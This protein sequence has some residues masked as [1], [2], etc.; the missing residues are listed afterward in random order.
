MSNSP[1]AE[2]LES[3]PDAI[4]RVDG[5]PLGSFWARKD[6]A[7]KDG[8]TSTHAFSWGAQTRT[9]GGALAAIGRAF[10]HVGWFLLL[11]YALVNLAY[12]TREI[13]YQ[14][15]GST[16]AWHGDTG[17]GTVRVFGLV[18]TLI[19]V[20]AFCSVAIDLVAVQCFRGSATEANQVCAALP[21]VFDGLRGL[22][23]DSRAA[24]LGLVPVV[25]ILVLY[26]IARSG[27]VR[28]EA[29][30][31]TFGKQIGGQGEKGRPLLATRGFWA[32][33]RSRDTTEWLHVAGS[34]LLV[35]FLL[36]FDASFP[37]ADCIGAPLTKD[38]SDCLGDPDWRPLV[39]VGIAAVGLVF[40]V[41]GVIISSSTP[42]REAEIP[43]D[44]SKKVKEA[45][46]PDK[47]NRR[48]RAY[49][50]VCL[51]YGAVGYIVWVALTFTPLTD[52][53]KVTTQFIGLITAPLVLMSAALFLALYAVSW[54]VRSTWRRRTSATVLTLGAVALML[55]QVLSD[56]TQQWMLTGAAVVLVLIHLLLS[57]T[58]QANPGEAKGESDAGELRFRAWRGQG[59]A[60]VML[61]SLFVSMALSSLL[62]LG[63]ASWLG[64]PEPG[65]TDRIW[66]TPGDPLPVT[67]WD[68]P[69][70]YERFAVLL[71]V[72]VVAILILLIV[73]AIVVVPKL[74]RF[75][76]PTLA[77][78][79]KAPKDEG[80]AESRGG[81][82]APPVRYPDKL[83]DPEERVRI[84]A[85][86]RRS[87][88]L[89]HRG[90]PLFAWIAVLAA[91]G[92]F[93]LSSSI[94]FDAAKGV[95][96]GWAPGLPA[97]LR[98]AATAI[99]VALALAAVAAVVAN[100]ATN[101][102]RPL[103]VF[104][105][106]V[107][108]FP[109]AGHPF[110]PPCFAERAV[111][112]LAE[113]TRQFL[114]TSAGD[115]LKPRSAVILTAH[116]MGSTISAATILAL[117]GERFVEEPPAGPQLTDRI[118]LL[119]YGS[120]LRGY[121]SR[122]F[123]SVFGYQVLGVPG[124]LAPSLWNPDPWKKQV[125]AEFPAPSQPGD[126]TTRAAAKAEAA[127]KATARQ[128]V[129]T[130]AFRKDSLAWMLGAS[131]TTLPRWRNLWRRT[132][133]LGFPVF[134]YDSDEN[135]VDRGATETAPGYQW[136]VAKHS[137]YLGTE[138]IELA[139]VEL[140]G[141][142]SKGPVV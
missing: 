28:F 127:A 125:V 31:E 18:L 133:F 5:D 22:D 44:P 59:A 134:S 122:F 95:L 56:S 90:E 117:R 76:L 7:A 37:K 89:L 46:S 70:A 105:D 137:A 29:R 10:V 123:P 110:A 141:E 69:D 136:T 132:D 119:S 42:L 60:V 73:A 135:P 103:G 24:L 27:R 14:R 126:E 115:P 68:V 11:P 67:D 49:A 43:T 35:L 130:H 138:Q 118:A 55:S 75:T 26:F 33:A 65:K 57:R 17:S 114:R 98:A 48:K 45:A 54:R 30:V 113:H 128:E 111:P 124:L 86:A 88:H 58:S 8:V 142:L 91:V 78:K 102:D 4:E 52:T 139:R 25:V 96:E 40:V 77:W 12:W 97:G 20:A 62:V 106:V 81:V 32:A 101:G 15:D 13:R 64:T 51:V 2:M 112:E 23:V 41:I 66:R 93:S 84:R 72:V 1:P 19:A 104:W 47:R 63:V 74:V 85:T 108:F 121:F 82:E 94:V 109:R 21:A 99:L 79:G 38:L 53:S 83:V 50:F 140:V 39:F 71:M 61:L 120:Q 34:L 100:S 6:K 116:S 16:R 9:G 129:K 107:A 36:A 80:D 92:F 3:E 131:E 87:S